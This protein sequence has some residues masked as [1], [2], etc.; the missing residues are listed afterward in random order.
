MLPFLVWDL[1][2]WR[3]W[4]SDNIRFTCS[5]IPLTVQMRAYTQVARGRS[6]L[7][8][9]QWGLPTALEGT[10]PRGPEDVRRWVLRPA[11]QAGPLT[12][13]GGLC[14]CLMGL[15]EH[16]FHLTFTFHL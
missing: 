4:L 15:T 12:P 2:V 6:D 16:K 1:A 13:S 8:E 11:P 14:F 9:R 3:D 5:F 10:L 7:A